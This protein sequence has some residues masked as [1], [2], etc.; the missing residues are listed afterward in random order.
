MSQLPMTRNS[1][2]ALHLKHQLRI[3]GT[4]SSVWYEEDMRMDAEQLEHF[5]R[6]FR[7]PRWLL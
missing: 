4:L 3:D 1:V 7:Y 5:H 6:A 2:P